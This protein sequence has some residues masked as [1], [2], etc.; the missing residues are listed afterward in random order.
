M[1]CIACLKTFEHSIVSLNILTWHWIFLILVLQT[2]ECVY[3]YA[4]TRKPVHQNYFPNY[5]V[6]KQNPKSRVTL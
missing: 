3:K 4:R 5:M 2:Y 6:P 1:T